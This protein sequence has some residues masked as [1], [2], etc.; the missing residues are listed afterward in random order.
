MG[1]IYVNPEGPNGKPDPVASGHD[2]RETFGRM[3][4]NDEETV[5]LVAGG[6]TFGKTHGAAP[7]IHVGPEPEGEE[8][9]MMGLGWKNDFNSGVGKDTISSGIEGPWTPNPI[10][11]DTGYFDVLFG[12]EWQLTKSPAGAWLWTPKDLP[13]QDHAPQVDGSDEVVP[14]IMTT[15][16]MALRMDEKYEK[17]S[18]RFHENPDEFADAFARA[19]YKLTHRDMG[20]RC[21][22]LGNEVPNEELIWQDP[23]P[24]VTH[25][26]INDNDIQSL[27]NDI[28]TSGLTVQELVVTAWS[29]ASTFR[30]SDKRGGANGARI[31]LSPQSSWEANNPDQLAKVLDVLTGIQ[32]TFNGKQLRSKRVSLAD[33]IVL[34]GCAAIEKA[35]ADAGHDIQV[36][37]TA[38]RTDAS[39]EQTD[40]ESFAVL[41]PIAD[42][43]RN[44]EKTSYTIKAEELMVDKAQ[45]MTL[46]APEMTVLVGGMRALGANYDASDLGVL[47]HRVGSLTND[48]F[49]NILDM[50]VEWKPVSES[51]NV[52]EGR[53]RNTGDLIWTASRVDLVFGSNSQLRALSEFYAYSDNDAKFVND[54]V[55]AW[56]KVMTLDRFDLSSNSSSSSSSGFF[57]SKM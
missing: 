52:F 27:K 16:D 48:F 37:F 12:Y 46:S 15:A 50:G 7:D 34:G 21:L 14:I 23:V 47:T 8:L 35:A 5:A 40:A 22:L 3:A 29:S 24:A 11:W 10:K 13:K 57:K 17:I 2:I 39:Q 26:L 42:A 18:R 56:D 33:L 6:H 36:P 54:F 51:K 55:A 31:R 49:V 44:Y 1:L 25:V 53:N 4:M 28:M 38:G 19:W 30:N 32:N 45:L 41:E 20:P 9:E 43:F